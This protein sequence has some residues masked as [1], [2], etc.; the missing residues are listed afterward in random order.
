MNIAGVEERPQSSALA[1]RE[2]MAESM[3]R[4]NSGAEMRESC[5]TAIF[6]SAA[7]LPLFS[8]RKSKKPP[9]MRLTASA[10][11]LTGSS[12]TPATATPR[13]SLPFC[14]FIH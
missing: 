5:P 12:A 11:R 4:F 1:P 10:V 13:T 8:S 3:A 14:N 6:S 9:A 2:R 7:F